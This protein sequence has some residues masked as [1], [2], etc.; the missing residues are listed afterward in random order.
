[1]RQALE[2]IRQAG[3]SFL[4]AGRALPSESEAQFRTLAELNLPPNLADLFEALPES[5]FRRDI[6]STQ[7]R[8][9]D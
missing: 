6:S 2:S 7:L 5:D 4:V 3:C 8:G 1:M 9:G